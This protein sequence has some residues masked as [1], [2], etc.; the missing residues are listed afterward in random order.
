MGR[1]H[2]CSYALSLLAFHHSAGRRTTYAPRRQLRMDY[3]D[4]CLSLVRPIL[5]AATLCPFFCFLFSIRSK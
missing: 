2:F 3:G 5:M 4:Q 1:K